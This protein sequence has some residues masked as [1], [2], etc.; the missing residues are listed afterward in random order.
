MRRA[1]FVVIAALVGVAAAA[2]PALASLR[3]GDVD[4]RR[5]PEVSMVIATGGREPFTAAEVHVLENGQ[6]VQPIS[7][8]PLGSSAGRVDAVLAIDVSNSM[9]GSNLDTALAAA[10]LFVAR[11]PRWVDVGVLAF[12]DTVTVMSPVTSD[13]SAVSSSVASIGAGTTQGT[14]L[15]DAIV[16]ASGLFHGPGQHNLIVVTDG[17]NTSTG[18]GLED[19]VAAARDVGM[20]IYPIGLTG[21]QTDAVTLQALADATGGAF[22]SISA[23]DLDAVYASLAQQLGAQY[24]VRYVS[25]APR[26]IT[27]EIT[28]STPSGTDTTH[29]LT[30]PIVHEGSPS[31]APSW[32]YTSDVGLLLAVLL[33]FLA[34]A[35]FM[36]MVTATRTQARRERF[37]RDRLSTPTGPT[38]P[39]VQGA[40]AVIPRPVAEAAEWGAQATGIA[41]PIDRLLERAAWRLTVGELLGG[42]MLMALVAGT[43]VGVVSRQALGAVLA[44]AL[45]AAVPYVVL[46]RAAR[47]RADALQGQLSDVLMVLASALRAGH[48]FLQALDTVSKEVGDPAAAEFSRALAEIRLGR[49]VDDALDALVARIGSQDLEWAVTAI[50]IQRRVGGNLAEVLETLA[51]TIRERETLRRQMRVLSSEGRLSVVILTVLPFLIGTYVYFVNPTYLH[52]LI[53]TPLGQMLMVGAGLLMVV[54]VVW[55]R[56]IVRLDV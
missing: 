56:R 31:S 33:S 45:V 16:S 13:R 3:I 32:L 46:S 43:G 38:R 48:S 42:A 29:V 24:V 10:Q 5:F 52:A 34:A 26:G 12:A 19:A 23:K 50:S 7:V 47:R 6:P 20:T 54:G 15:F 17:R 9:R 55:M 8:I 22:A 27:T 53:G 18:T 1:G 25:R 51:D 39:Q 21:P 40:G 49:S 2:A 14:A 35:S 28:V 37:L 41:A 36:T 44:A 30:P 4:T 11:V